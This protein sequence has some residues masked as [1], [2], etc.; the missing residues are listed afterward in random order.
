MTKEQ[1]EACWEHSYKDCNKCLFID[2]PYATD[3]G[4]G[5]EN[6]VEE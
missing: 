5:F 4:D 6:E 3:D 2:C 1:Y